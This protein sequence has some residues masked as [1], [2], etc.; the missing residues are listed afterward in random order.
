MRC[1]SAVGGAAKQCTMW[2]FIF[3]SIYIHR[4]KSETVPLCFGWRPLGVRANV[5]VYKRK[6]EPNRRFLTPSQVRVYTHSGVIQSVRPKH[7]STFLGTINGLKLS[8]WKCCHKQCLS[9]LISMNSLYLSM[10]FF[11]HGSHNLFF[12]NSFHTLL[13]ILQHFFNFIKNL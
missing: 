9:K 3:D 6:R 4:L 12:V 2:V 11:K 5:C 8:L 1:L 10:K 13:I 7:K